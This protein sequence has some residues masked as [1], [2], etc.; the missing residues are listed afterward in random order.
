MMRSTSTALIFTAVSALLIT[1]SSSMSS[2]NSSQFVFVDFVDDELAANVSARHFNVSDIH[3]PTVYHYQL[4]QKILFACFMLPIIFLSI[5]GNILVVI[6]ISKYKFLK[7]TNNIFL[8]SLAV[9]DCAVGIL[10]MTLNA[11]QL[12]SGKWYL[13]AFMC[14]FWLASDVLFS[15]GIC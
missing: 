11:L 12:L 13:G 9:A 8:A 2:F 1:V 15:T 3:P 6:A 14:R 10:A 7:I 4:W 5:L